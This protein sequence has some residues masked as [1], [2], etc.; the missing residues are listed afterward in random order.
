M[1]AEWPAEP[2]SSRQWGMLLILWL[3]WVIV[4]P[5][6]I[7]GHMLVGSLRGL[8]YGT[9]EGARSAHQLLSDWWEMTRRG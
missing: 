4:A 6:E 8:S 2:L 7:V 3:M 9:F 5:C 1:R